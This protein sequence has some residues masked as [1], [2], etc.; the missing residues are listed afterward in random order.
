MRRK[1][2]TRAEKDTIGEF[3]F[4]SVS[5]LTA[6]LGSIGWIDF[7]NLSTSIFCFV[8]KKLSKGTPGSISDIPI[9]ASMPFGKH[10]IDRQVFNTYCIIRVD[11]SSAFLMS[12]IISSIRNSFVNLNDNLFSF[13][14]F[15]S[16][17]CKFGKFSLSFCQRL[18]F[19]LKE[20]WISHNR[21]IRKS[22][23]VFNTHIN[24]NR[25]VY[26]GKQF[27]L[28]FTREAGI[29]FL[30]N[31]ANSAGLNFTQ[32]RPMNDS[33]DVT[34]FR[35]CKEV[36]YETISALRESERIVSSKAFVTRKARFFFSFNSA[37]E[38]LVG[39]VNSYRNILQNLGMYLGKNFLFILASYKRNSLRMI[40]NALL[41]FFPSNISLGKKRIVKQTAFL[42]PLRH[43]PFLTFLWKQSNFKCLK[44]SR[45]YS[46]KCFNVKQKFNKNALHLPAKASSLTA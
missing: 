15:F 45:Y 2:T 3:H 43:Q 31:S 14:S 40:V 20:F 25:F 29:P 7:D 38:S 18:A 12:K 22:C 33:F 21:S 32:N 5:A 10:F 9:E 35:K 6:S 27:I 19:L 13:S 17:S 11:Y 44:H 41:F 23:E 39:K 46:L 28:N 1:T 37:K 36:I 16:S 26:S 24:A 30:I 4:V 8:G 42:K 34:N